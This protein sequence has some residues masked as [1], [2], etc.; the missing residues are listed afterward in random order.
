[1]QQEASKR[2]GMAAKRTMAVAQSLY[3]GVDT[4]GGARVGLITYMRTDSTSIA[5]AAQAEAREYIREK[6][7]EHFCPPAPPVYK[8]KTKGAQ[9]A[10]EAIRPTSV[11]RDPASLKP[12]LDRD[13]YRLYDLI[14]KRFVASQMAAAIL[15]VT[16][17]DVT[18]TVE[19]ETKSEERSSLLAPRSS[20]YLFRATGS[21][22]K[23][24]GF[25]AVYEEARE[26]ETGEDDE[27]RGVRLP[28]L[29][30]SEP[31]DLLRLIPEQH[32]TQPP[33]RYTEASLVKALE[34]FGIGRPSTYAPILT[35]IQTRGYVVKNGKQLAPT[36]LGFVTNDLLVASVDKYVAVD[37]TAQMEDQLDEVAEGKLKWVGML[38]EFYG[39]FAASVE[40]ARIS[41]P[42]VEVKPETTG[43]MCPDCGQPLVFKQGRF[44]RFIACSH[45]PACRHTEPLVKRTGVK[46]PQCG[47]D[48]L[49]RKTKKGRIFYGCA[50]YKADD[51]SS[52]KFTTWKRPLAQPCPHCGGLL[53]EA[54]K[55]KAQC[56]K[57]RRISD[58]P[59]SLTT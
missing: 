55:N 56:F 37:F 51:A 38:R 5:P 22:I 41:A 6:F 27:G 10:H 19:R 35:T 29:A 14:W 42:R 26:G 58:L 34:E 31:L 54:G 9:E 59:A 40:Q 48:L 49:E 2:L 36:E 1:L 21:V 32:F 46:C 12:Y 57:C 11:R 25:L 16:S 7:G 47:K 15:D 20:L 43:Q 13:Q 53:L 44:G 45:Y 33:P 3:E 24:A 23:F 18:A 17:V 50:G 52:C 39:P 30:V 4:G 28:P 8:T